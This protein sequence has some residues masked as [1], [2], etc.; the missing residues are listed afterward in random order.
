VLVRTKSP[1]IPI[2]IVPRTEAAELRQPTTMWQLLIWAYQRQK[3]HLGEADVPT[4]NRQDLSPTAVVV[5]RLLLGASI[6]NGGH[7]FGP[8]GGSGRACDADALELHGCVLKLGKHAR[9]LIET[10]SVGQA[11]D[12]Q[13]FYPPARVS[14]V[15]RMKR[16]QRVSVMLYDENRNPINACKIEITGF[17]PDRARRWIEHHR[18]IYTKWWAALTVLHD[19]LAERQPLK[20]WLI[21]GVG[22]EPNPWCAQ[23]RDACR[24]SAPRPKQND[25]CAYEANDA[26]RDIPAVRAAPFN[27]PQPEQRGDDVNAA[28]C[29]ICTAGDVAF[30]QRQEIGEGRERDEARDE[31][32]HWLPQAQPSPKCEAAGNF[33]NGGTG[34]GEQGLHAPPSHISLFPARQAGTV[35]AFNLRAPA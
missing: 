8:S 4:G 20:R 28:I 12:W 15:W 18:K 13:P 9:R 29:C 30:N 24:M 31:P 34:V 27:C 3:A 26:S 16:G 2:S 1:R 21:R 23:G 35:D 5:Q 7:G 11:P 14:P 25:G 32:P 33:C 6:D 10:A 19:W 17:A 22:A